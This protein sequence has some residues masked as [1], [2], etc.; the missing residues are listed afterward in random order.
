MAATNDYSAFA[1]CLDSPARNGFAITPHDSN[2]LTHVT[3]G[4]YVGGTGNMVVLTMNDESVTLVGLPAG[5]LIPIRAKRVDS[6]S[7]TA[8]S[9]VGLW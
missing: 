9:M 3:R 6:T 5:S 4:I 8:T 7:T 2:E 1:S